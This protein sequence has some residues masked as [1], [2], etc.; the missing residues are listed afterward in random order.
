VVNVGVG[1]KYC[2]NLV[3]GKQQRLVVG[4]ITALL[5][6]AVNQQLFSG[7]FNAVAAAGNFTGG[8]KECQLHT[9]H[10]LSVCSC[11]GGQKSCPPPLFLLYYNLQLSGQIT[12]KNM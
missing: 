4:G 1:D 12:F 6:T 5:H 9:R 11:L 8:T 2:V 7:N 3:G 10:N